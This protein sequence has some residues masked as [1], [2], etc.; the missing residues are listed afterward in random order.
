MK[1]IQ[2][3]EMTYGPTGDRR[4]SLTIPKRQIKTDS[5]TRP[6]NPNK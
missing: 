1:T 4:E 5:L 2:D 6:K 3:Q